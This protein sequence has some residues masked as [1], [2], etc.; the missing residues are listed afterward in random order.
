MNAIDL[1][2]SL[3]EPIRLRLMH[4]LSNAGPE[5]CVCDLVAVLGSPQGTISRHLTHLRLVGLVADRRE[6]VWV[7]YRLAPATTKA[8]AAMLRCLESCFEDDQ[9]LAQDLQQY[10][11]LKKAKALACC[12]PQHL[13]GRPGTPNSTPKIKAKS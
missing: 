10:V 4:L 7:Y 2:K 12:S 11:S 8:H 5:L 1:F 13:Q 9:M 3:S 6:G